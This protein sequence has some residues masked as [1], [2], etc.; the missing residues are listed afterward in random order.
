MADVVLENVSK[1]FGLF[2]AVDDLSIDIEN[3]EFLILVGPSGCGKSTALRMVAGLEK[4]SGGELRIGGTRMNGVAPKDRDIAMVFQNY[5]LYP[6]MSVAENIGFAL[7]LRG[8]QKSERQKRVLDVARTLELD[9]MLDKKPNELSGGQRQRVAMGRAIVRKPAA[10]LMD[11]PL[12]NL[13]AKLRVQ[14]RTE[15]TNLQ[16]LLGV[17]TIYVT[18]DQV[19]AMTM[20]TR[21]AV[22]KDGRLQQIDAPKTLYHAPANVFVAGF[23]GSPAM[24][25]FAGKV[26]EGRIAAGSFGVAMPDAVRKHTGVAGLDTGADVIFGVRPEDI[27]V[28][29]SAPADSDP[30]GSATV[31][32]LEEPGSEIIVHMQT[33]MVKVDSGDPD[34]IEEMEHSANLIAK[35]NAGADIVIGQKV[36]L[37]VKPE[38]VHA[39]DPVSRRNLRI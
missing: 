31:S 11:E 16:R 36:N 19:E 38:M 4:I 1:R 12:S 5:A 39:F 25:L 35:L 10:F 29:G 8:V 13:D 37:R 20:G 6:H 27:Y 18:H 26:S 30:F 3:G 23:I 7:R 34:A 9:A 17:T 32:S 28:E 22:L 15:I 14:M 33:D 21:V 24:N 2:T